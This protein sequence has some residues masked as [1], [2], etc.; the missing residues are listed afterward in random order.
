[1]T[2]PENY[3]WILEGHEPVSVDRDTWAAWYQDTD[4]HVATDT[5]PNGYWISTVFLGFNYAMPGQDEPV[6][7]ETMVFPGKDDMHDLDQV[8]YHTYAEA[9]AGHVAMVERW[10]L[11]GESHD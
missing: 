5:L 6:L 2:D 9:E 10:K 11:E 3:Y 8:R 1:M 7:F 4:R